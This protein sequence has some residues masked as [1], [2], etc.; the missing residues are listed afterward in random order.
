VI[1]DLIQAAARVPIETCEPIPTGQTIE[2]AGK[3]FR[4]CRCRLNET[5]AIN[6]GFCEKCRATN[7]AALY[8]EVAVS[9]W[10][11]Q[12][13]RAPWR[14][15][16]PGRWELEAPPC[17]WRGEVQRQRDRKCCGGFV[18]VEKTVACTHPAVDGPVAERACLTCPRRATKKT[19]KEGKS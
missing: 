14:E 3:R 11:A 15:V 18:R 1:A 6:R 2:R 7:R 8:E 4:L 16:C 19:K 17:Q 12:R 10:H 13:D 5:I 9:R